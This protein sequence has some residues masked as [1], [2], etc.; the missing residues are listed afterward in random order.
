MFD[1]TPTEEFRR[2]LEESL[3]LSVDKI[4]N[5]NFDIVRVQ[6]LCNNK[7]ISEGSVLLERKNGQG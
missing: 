7:V 6:L 3:K 1:E 2:R 5:D 4:I